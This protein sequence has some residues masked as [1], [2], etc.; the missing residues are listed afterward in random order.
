VLAHEFGHYYSGDTRLGPWVYNTRQAM[1]RV[2]ENLGKKSSV[3]MFLTR[4]AVVSALYLFLMGGMRLY[5]KLFMRITQAISRKQEL[6]SDELACHV[7]GSQALIDGLGSIRRCGAAVDSYWNSEVLPVAVSGFQPQLAEGFQRF[8]NAPE[9]A[10]AMTEYV[11]RESADEKPSPFDTHPPMGV[12]MERAKTL[13]LP[14]P[15]AEEAR[16][17]DQLMISLIDDLPSLEGALLKKYVPALAE[18]ELKPLAWDA[19]GVTVYVPLWRKEISDFVPAFG[20]STLKNLPRLVIAPQELMN[21]N[22]RVRKL[23]AEERERLA[24]AILFSA[25]A[26]C[27]FD[28]GWKLVA[29]PGVL[30]FEFGEDQLQPGETLAAMKSGKM[31][32]QE[33]ESYCAERG[34]ADWLLASVEVPVASQ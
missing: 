27:L 19:T 3:L 12:R 26:L 25:L 2:Y 31:T 18:A 24:K 34:I 1:V 10:K 9:I 14:V 17:N 29:E 21:Q 8:T 13:N 23:H 20:A 32:A 15:E 6:R 30:Y 22:A 33:W 7:A 4:W 28:H 11:A 5:W 16:R